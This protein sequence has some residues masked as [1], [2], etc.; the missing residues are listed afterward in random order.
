LLD[1]LGFT[2]SERVFDDWMYDKYEYM[3][4]VS[5]DWLKE[6][7]QFD[8]DSSLKYALSCGLFDNLSIDE[9]DKFSDIIEEQ[10]N[11]SENS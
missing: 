7:S 6:F 2:Y 11:I 4:R 10:K 9:Y 1:L 8:V 3:V 5:P